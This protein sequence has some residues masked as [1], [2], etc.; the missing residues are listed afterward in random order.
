M[1]ENSDSR[2]DAVERLEVARDEQATRS[3]QYD[4]ASGSSE[5]LSASTRLNAAEDQF[6]AREAWLK[7]IDRDYSAPFDEA[8]RMKKD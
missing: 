1:K 7:W 3:E 8:S 5:E 4:A 6:A 2:T